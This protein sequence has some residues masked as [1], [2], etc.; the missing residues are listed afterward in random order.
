M[1]SA[2]AGRLQ[3]HLSLQRAF[4]R[5]GY[6]CSRG[7]SHGGV[8]VDRVLSNWS[9]L[10]PAVGCVVGTA[11]AVVNLPELERRGDI[12]APVSLYTGFFKGL[13]LGSV[14]VYALPG[15]CVL[16]PLAGAG[17]ALGKVVS[18]AIDS[19]HKTVTD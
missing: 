8:I 12:L 11:A 14:A 3:A 4:A 18:M 5:S 16:V 15:L 1:F 2:A 19:P 7:P 13:V 9:L 10:C 6:S 17:V